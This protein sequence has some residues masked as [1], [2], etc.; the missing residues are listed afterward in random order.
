MSFR[1]APRSPYAVTGTDNVHHAVEGRK[2]EDEATEFRER[3]LPCFGV[4][5]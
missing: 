2:T 3:M 1:A 4:S 5:R